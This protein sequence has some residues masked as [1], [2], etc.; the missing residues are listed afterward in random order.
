MPL[1]KRTPFFAEYRMSRKQIVL[2]VLL[3]LGFVLFLHNISG[4]GLWRDEVDSIR[5]TA[6]IW[7][8]LTSSNSL[9]GAAGELG[10]YLTRPGWNGPFYFWVLHPWLQLAGQSELAL[11]YPSALAAVMAVALCYSLGAQLFDRPTGRLAALLAILNPYLNWYAGEGKMYTLITVLALLSTYWLIRALASGR[12]RFWV[13]YTAITT[14]LFYTHILSPLL[15]PVQAGLVLLLYPRALRTAALWLAAAALTLPYLPLV[16]W[17]W[18]LLTEAAETGFPFV[19]WPDMVRR[20]SQV[21][22]RGIIGWPATVPQIL[23]LGAMAAGFAVVL[24]AWKRHSDRPNLRRELNL[25]LW[26]ALPLLELYLVSLRRPLFTERYLIWTLPAWLLLAAWGLVSLGRQGRAGRSWALIWTAGLA[27]IGLL[28][29]GRQWATP[30]RADLRAAAEIIQ[31]DY[32]AGDLILFQIPYL[33]HT[34]DYYAQDF[35]YQAAEGPYTNYG[36][37]PQTVD[38]HLCQLTAGY[39]RVWLVLSEASM[40]DQRGLTRAW[41]QA[42]ESRVQEAKLNRVEL[43]LWELGDCAIETPAP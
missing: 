31:G 28:G 3:L 37:P 8:D 32:Q 18:P 16:S 39:Q 9:K 35:D 41:F 38:A 2:P 19:P 33:Q 23:L 25:L 11:R 34:F 4:E 21:F 30:V 22:A 5:F 6:E 29:I 24:I 15:L 20:L 7:T 36:D 40:W 1:F 10:S 27:V 13:A 42:Q 17:Q 43:S 14:L 12:T 26:G